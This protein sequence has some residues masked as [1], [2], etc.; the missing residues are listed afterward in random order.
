MNDWVL[1]SWRQRVWECS[2][3]SVSSWV[4][5]VTDGCVPKWAEWTGP[6]RRQTVR[7]FCK[8]R[9][10]RPGALALAPLG[11]VSHQL[12]GRGQLLPQ[13][14]GLQG[15]RACSTLLTGYTHFGVCLDKMI[16]LHF[17]YS[18]LLPDLSFPLSG[19]QASPILALHLCWFSPAHLISV[20]CFSFLHSSVPVLIR[21]ELFGILCVCYL[22]VVSWPLG[23]DSL[24]L[25]HCAFW[26]PTPGQF[27]CCFGNRSFPRNVS[28]WTC[29]PLRRD[30]KL[31]QCLYLPHHSWLFW[32]VLVAN[33]SYSCVCVCVC[34]RA[35][36]HMCMFL[37]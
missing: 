33:L 6:G 37:H 15:P 19:W 14:Q 1:H 13:G 2:V 10:P 26:F 22:I 3:I 23:L 18:S 4:Q 16:L 28:L 11:E 9:G 36:T 31:T 30:S 21:T 34:V 5:G 24:H 20:P 12:L 25:D 7:Q 27:L 8:A 35:H 17:P 29:W 32:F